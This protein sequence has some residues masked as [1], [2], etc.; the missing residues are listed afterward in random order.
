MVER[1][2]DMTPRG[3]LLDVSVS[4]REKGDTSQDLIPIK[5]SCHNRLIKYE[6]QILD[7]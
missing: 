4:P 5:I 1:L 7:E 2:N 3:M 6:N